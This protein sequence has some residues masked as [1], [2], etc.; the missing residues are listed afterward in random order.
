MK[1]HRF[2]FSAPRPIAIM[3]GCIV[4]ALSA[5]GGPPDRDTRPVE[6]NAARFDPIAQYETVQNYAGPNAQ[7]LEIAAYYVRSDGTLDL[8]ASYGARVDYEFY[9]PT[10]A[11]GKEAPPLGAG[12]TGTDQWYQTVSVEADQPGRTWHIESGSS[13]YS[14]TNQGLTREWDTPQNRI[15]GTAIPAPECSFATL[16]Q[17]ALEREAPSEAVAIIRYDEDGYEFSISDTGIRL[18]FDTDCSLERE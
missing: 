9:R 3:M 12:G 15:P 18:N 7:L 6:G 14:F 2:P 1:Q 10:D 4:F 13:E 8:T 17:I 5:C 16:W 11:E